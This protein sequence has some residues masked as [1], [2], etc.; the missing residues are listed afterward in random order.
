VK[1]KGI[2]PQG[3]M[4]FGDSFR[5]DI[6]MAEE[7]HAQRFPVEFIYVGEEKIDA[8][9]YPFPIRLTKNKY[10]KGTLEF[11]KSL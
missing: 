9:K 3:Y 1:K 6:P 2:K 5:S 10:G 7:L 4:A 11:L 8:S